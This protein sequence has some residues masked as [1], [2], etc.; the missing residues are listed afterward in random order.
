MLK[1]RWIS[2]GLTLAA[3]AA[4]PSL[5]CRK[6]GG[7]SEAGAPAAIASHNTASVSWETS[8]DKAF[9]RAQRENKAVLIDF[10]ADWCVWCRRLDATTYRDPKVVGFLSDRVVPLKLNVDG[11]EGRSMASKYH[12]DGLPTIVILSASGREIGRIP[13]YMPAGAFLEQVERIAGSAGQKG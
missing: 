5:G 10:Y 7:A 6:G 9:K 12:V 2:I 1:L 11:G 13:G 3:L 4:L 8:W